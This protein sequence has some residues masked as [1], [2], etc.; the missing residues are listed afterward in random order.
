M[1]NFKFWQ[2]NRSQGGDTRFMDCFGADPLREADVRP[3][4]GSRTR[5]FICSCE[6]QISSGGAENES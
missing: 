4:K 6:A 3:V 5:S 1:R 2:K